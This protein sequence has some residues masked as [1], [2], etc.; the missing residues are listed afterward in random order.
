MSGASIG[1]L[2][3]RLVIEAPLETTDANGDRRIVFQE[4]GEIWG[5]VEPLRSAGQFVADRPE[6]L[7]THVV[8]ARWRT[9]VVA[10]MRLRMADRALLIRAV[11]NPDER[12]IRMS[13]LC[14]EVQ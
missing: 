11:R 4:A 6:Q 2:R 3:H 14:E 10:G 5:D 12:K 9:D 1:T 7:T 8:N 13:C